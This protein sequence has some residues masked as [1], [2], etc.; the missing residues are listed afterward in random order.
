MTSGVLR[1]TMPLSPNQLFNVPSEA[2]IEYR[3]PAFDPNTI[4]AER[5]PPP[6]QYA[7]PRLAGMSSF[8]SW[9]RHFSAPEVASNAITAPYGDPTYI[10]LPM[11]MG[12]A[13]S[14]RS[15]PE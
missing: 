7:T 13:S 4:D 12:I 11:T 1:L 6:G 3:R 9:Y 2:L 14:S 10:V 15:L 5:P 8:G